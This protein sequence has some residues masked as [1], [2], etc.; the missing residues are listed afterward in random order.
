MHPSG[1]Y[2]GQAPAHP[3]GGYAPPQGAQ[4]GQSFP[5]PPW[6][7]QNSYAMEHQMAA[8]QMHGHY[9]MQ[10]TPPGA[11]PPNYAS[12][13]NRNLYV[14][15]IG[16]DVTQE[17]LVNAF[18]PFGHVESVKMIPMKGCAFIAFYYPESAANAMRDMQGARVKSYELRLGWGKPDSVP[19]GQLSHPQPQTAPVQQPVQPPGVNP[20]DLPQPSQNY[21]IPQ[22]HSSQPH[23]A[24][25]SSQASVTA[26]A[27]APN[28]LPLPP[29]DPELKKTIDKLLEHISQS[30]DGMEAKIRKHQVDN[31]KFCFLFGGEGGEYYNYM[32]SSV[33]A[34]VPLGTLHQQMQAMLD[35]SYQSQQT[36]PASDHAQQV[37]HQ[38]APQKASTKES[39]Q[40]A[41]VTP[42]PTEDVTMLHKILDGLDG[43]KESIKKGKDWILEHHLFKT[44]LM[45]VIV[46]RVASYEV[47]ERKLFVIYLMNDVLYH[48]SKLL[49]IYREFVACLIDAAPQLFSCAYTKSSVEKQ[50]RL[51]KVLSIWKDRG[52]ITE[53]QLANIEYYMKFDMNPLYV[54]KPKAEETVEETALVEKLEGDQLQVQSVGEPM[55]DDEQHHAQYPPQEQPIGPVAL[56][57]GPPVLPAPHYHPPPPLPTQ[58]QPPLQPPLLPMGPMH[59]AGG[60]PPFVPMQHPGP[61]IPMMPPPG[62]GPVPMMPHG[63][64]YP[65]QGMPLFP[66][67]A[68]APP[69]P[70]PGPVPTFEVT[71]DMVPVGIMATYFKSIPKPSAYT[72]LDPAAGS[73]FL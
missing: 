18:S 72:A 2:P 21:T 67:M 46:K 64:Q 31:P 69:P 58:S 30:G 1:G 33:L 5:A 7:T 66:P 47:F 26:Q 57:T 3:Y 27:P 34:G 28:Y 49:D 44:S 16:Q 54:Q 48:C 52:H 24:F 53:A 43:S 9:H 38:A 60:P 63:L 59:P 50:A 11:A 25:P 22:Q 51:S 32:K 70:F 6:A 40:D 39:E 23:Q 14:G 68:I 17:D 19:V 35:A 15:G 20:W 55:V 65:H 13:P 29:Q 4:Y 8:Q 71:P 62:Q 61:G 56:P 37:A 10:Q 41:N 42:L 12:Q 73:F 36:R 45:Q